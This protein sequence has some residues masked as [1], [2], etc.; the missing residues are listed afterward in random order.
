MSCADYEQLLAEALGDE[1][2]AADAV[3]LD[4]HLRECAACRQEFAQ[5][6]AAV[7][8]LR[9]L[10]RAEHVPERALDRGAG[11]RTGG[12]VGRS[13]GVRWMQPAL[14]YAAVVIMAF[15]AGYAWKGRTSPP[16][17]AADVSDMVVDPPSRGAKSF[18]SALARAY[19]QN[20][21]G[22]DLAKCMSALLSGG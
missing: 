22:S 20:P 4:E 10:P 12:Q 7:A 11:F 3:R 14:R 6:T 17:Q 8:A 2:S 16:G 21:A 1:L 9:R 18:E 13:A 15:T 5:G 19:R